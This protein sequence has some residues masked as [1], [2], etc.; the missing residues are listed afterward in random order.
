MA[1]TETTTVGYGKRL[2]GSLKGILIGFLLFIVGTVLLWWNEGRAVKTARSIKGAYEQTIKE[3]PD[4]SSVNS[5]LNGKMICVSGLATTNDLVIDQFFGV[6]ANAIRI[7]RKVEFYQWVERSETKTEDKVGG[8][9]EKTTTYN[10]NKEW[11]SAP[12]ESAGFHDSNYKGKNTVVINSIRSEKMQAQNVTVG[13]YTLP[14]SMVSSIS[15]GKQMSISLSAEKQDE[16][17]KAVAQALGQGDG[18]F[19]T[20]SGNQI[21]LGKNS[22]SPEIGDVRISFTQVDPATVTVWAKVKDNTFEKF[23]ASNDYSVGGLYMGAKTLD[24]LK[25]QSESANSVLTW[26]FRIVGLVLVYFGFKGIFN[27][28]VTLLK[29]LPFL[30]KIANVGVS[31]VCGVLGFAWSLIIIAIAWLFYRPILAIIL[32]A[33]VVGLFVFLSKRS[34]DAQV[35]AEPSAQA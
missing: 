11:V 25:E 28:V 32:I 24:E 6:S 19:V 18:Q 12:V 8:K 1:Y 9:Q 20:I 3:S 16:L 30:A 34:K 21:Y 22:N 26:L 33:I 23:V 31:I 14:Q 15:G 17:N 4:L 13:A 7:E 10:Y 27:I 29:V 5:D 2:S 35:P